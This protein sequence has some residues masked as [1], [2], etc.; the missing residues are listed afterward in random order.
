MDEQINNLDTFLINN[1]FD[2]KKVNI[3]MSLVWINMSPLY[4]GDLRW[5]LF[6]FGKYNLTKYLSQ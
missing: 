5:F 4:D 2:V 1:N 6:Y 3:L